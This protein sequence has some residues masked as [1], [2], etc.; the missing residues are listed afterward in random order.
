[1]A[2]IAKFG[3]TSAKDGPTLEHIV[4]NIILADPA[5]R[6][7]V[8]SAPGKRF[9]EDTKVTDLLIQIGEKSYISKEY[10]AQLDELKNRFVG[11]ADYFGSGHSFLDSAFH[12]LDDVIRSGSGIKEEYLDR[13]KPF[14]EMINSDI[15]AEVIRR[16]GAN[17]KVYR[18]ENIGFF[19][20]SN[21]GN[22]KL[23]EYSYKKISEALTSVLR[24]SDEIIVVPGFYGIDEFGKYATFSRGGSD[25]TGAILAN[26]LNAELYEN[27]TDT[28]GIRRA[29]PKIVEDAEV[30]E[31][32]TYREA[33]ELAYS[34]AEIL[35]PDTLIPLIAKGIPLNVRNTFNLNKKGTYIT[36]NKDANGHVVEGIAHKEGFALIHIEKTGMNDEVGY[37][38]RLT[39]IFD[40]YKI[41]IDQMTTSIDSVSIAVS[42][43]GNGEKI[44]KMLKDI[45]EE[46]LADA[47]AAN[48]EYDKALVC[49]VG[50][51]MRH[52]PGVLKRVSQALS[53]N[54]INI[55]TLYQGPSERSII[56]GLIQENAKKAVRAIYD[57]YFRNPSPQI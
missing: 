21:F 28:D 44:K 12:S 49:V 14:G 10:S 1:M 57:S 2:T 35:H 32:L 23:K 45:S 51:G 41:S 54:S 5:R 53:A 29:N 56:F 20:D 47:G 36:Q 22:A 33:R 42:A 18:P 25:L 43:N 8:I 30:I 9:S 11:I 27:W 6:I 38:H 17:A 4:K 46:G 40:N 55:E 26:A 7:V 37:L 50:E 19:T 3:G 15:L 13:I 52:T 39:K 24:K 31:R 34:G 16:F 48:V